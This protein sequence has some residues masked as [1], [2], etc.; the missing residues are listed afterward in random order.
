[1]CDNIYIYSERK[2]KSQGRIVGK[3]SQNRY[4]GKSQRDS[5]NNLITRVADNVVGNRFFL[6]VSEELKAMSMSFKER[7][8]RFSRIPLPGRQTKKYDMSTISQMSSV[9]LTTDYHRSADGQSRMLHT[10]NPS[11]AHSS[12]AVERGERETEKERQ[13]Q[14]LMTKVGD[15]LNELD[16]GI[17][18]AGHPS[19]GLLMADGVMKQDHVSSLRRKIVFRGFLLFLLIGIIGLIIGV[20]ISNPA[21]AN[22]VNNSADGNSGN[23]SAPTISPTFDGETYAPTT[24]APTSPPPTLAPTRP[25]TFAPTK[26]PTICF[27]GFCS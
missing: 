19:V 25:P 9:A 7:S 11:F 6:R 5:I 13:R 15:I 10:S 26:K 27:L 17:N 2:C 8:L 3:S 21:N 4:V 14:G 22:N 12:T 16:P 23:T 18:N 1:V 20:A 24:L